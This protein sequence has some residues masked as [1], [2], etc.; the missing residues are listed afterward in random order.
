MVVHHDRSG[1]SAIVDIPKM[2][3]CGANDTEVSTNVELEGMYNQNVFSVHMT[4][5]VMD[6]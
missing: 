6:K 1:F 3:L 4:L 5:L 2:L